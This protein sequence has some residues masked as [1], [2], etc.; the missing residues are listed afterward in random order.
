[1]SITFKTLTG[2]AFH[3]L[4]ILYTNHSTAN[5]ITVTSNAAS[6][7][8]TLAEA[9]QT[10]NTLPGADIIE[11]NLPAG[12]TTISLTGAGLPA[13][14]D[15]LFINGYSQSGASQGTISSR[16]IVVTIDGSLLNG[17]SD[18]FTI[19]SADV[20]IAG[21]SIIRSPRYAININQQGNTAHIWGNYL[22][23][24]ADGA[25]AG[26]G[27]ASGG[28]A[29]NLFNYGGAFN[30]GVVI[31]V[32]GD[33][34]N[35]INEGNLICSGT[36]SADGIILWNTRSAVIAG[37]II[38]FDKNLNTTAAGGSF[39][40][41]RNGILVT[42]TALNNTI[43]TNGD[44]TSDALEGNIIGNNG[45]VGLFL[46]QSH[47]NVIAGN[48]IGFGK[49]AAGNGREGI[50]IMNSHGNRVGTD[51]L[52]GNANDEKNTIVYNISDGIRLSTFDFLNMGN[53]FADNTN[54][55]IIAGNNI[56]ANAPGGTEAD[57]AN[58]GAGIL[59]TA[60]YSTFTLSNNI[61]GSN[62]DGSEDAAEGNHIGNNNNGGIV[63]KTTAGVAT[64]NKF[65]RN[66][67]FNNNNLLGIDLNADKVTSNDNG[68]SDAGVNNLLNFPVI[69]S[70]QVSA[71]TLTVRGF[72][73]P[74]AVIEFYIADAG[75]NPNP[76][77]GGYVTSFGEGKTF[78]FRGQDDATLDAADLLVGTTGNYNAS[79]EGTGTGGIRNEA[80]F[81]FSI[82]LS[83][84]Q[85]SVSAGTRITALA[86]E[87]ATGA[88]NTSE[89]GPVTALIPMPVQWLSI[90]SRYNN[91]KV[92]INWRTAEEI[93]NHHFEILKSTNGKDYSIIGKVAA[94]GSNSSYEFIDDKPADGLSYYK[95]R[96]VDFDNNSSE[97]KIMS[98]RTDLGVF[99]A[100][101]SPNPFKS[102]LELRFKLD[103]EDNIRVRIY[104]LSGVIVK[105]YNIRGNAGV[106]T[107][108]ITDL[109]NLPSGSYS[110]E[111]S[112]TQISYRQQLI[113]Q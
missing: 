81:R 62:N 2:I 17:G 40:H 53:T 11:F 7:A 72:S 113:K 18:V 34:L 69:T 108:S 41:S 65:S 60:E 28:I 32:D 82:P 103:R 90:G 50:H 100:R 35:D 25:T 9:I 24:S 48:I 80:E 58:G 3:V 56:G 4:A 63:A 84:L 111:L 107:S 26:L 83:S 54:D 95:I 21:L 94:K 91:G 64:G 73:R 109:G 52:N 77:P 47:D 22:G 36:N 85:G 78:L 71:T 12:S 99:T 97:S 89:F 20:S 79:Q 37:N 10:S 1:M 27:N 8:N 55:N 39:G 44:G 76:L 13:I 14:T 102:V 23:T 49:A 75:P 74:N 106:N 86:Y 98:V 5:T 19:N 88:G 68:D 43:G 29:V 6:G 46:V 67:I 112:G 70:V 92:H 110:L 61:I 38:G 96:Q 104:N 45:E 105:T 101:A 66:S 31:G 33:G 51:G 57:G 59:L 93:N 30:T 42:V 16:V 87:S 15:E